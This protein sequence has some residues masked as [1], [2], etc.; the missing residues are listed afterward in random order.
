M[1]NALQLP[2]AQHLHV[3][4]GLQLLVTPAL[5]LQLL[6]LLGATMCGEP[7]RVPSPRQ[8]PV[9]L[10]R[11]RSAVH[12]PHGLRCVGRL[13]VCVLHKSNDPV[14]GAVQRNILHIR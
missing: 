13:A 3:V 8:L 4:V 10:A 11:A 2:I 9:R 12:N 6:L 5:L 7:A 1:G 14:V